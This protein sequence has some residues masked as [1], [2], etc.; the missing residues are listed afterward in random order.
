MFSDSD[1][2]RQTVR[3]LARASEQG[4]V[5]P[6]FDQGQWEMLGEIG[7]LGLGTDS[8][9]GGA[10]EIVCAMEELGAAGFVGPLVE[11]FI[12]T[13]TVTGTL[14]EKLVA[15]G[16]A[17]VTWNA[18]II[19]WAN[20]A[21]VTVL[22]G[23]RDE[24][25]VCTTSALEPFNTLGRD[26]SS[27]GVCEPVTSL[28]ENSRAVAIGE[29]AISGYII[30]ASQRLVQLS[31]E[32][33][34][35]RRQFGKSIGEFQAVSHPLAQCQA[36]LNSARD[37]LWLAARLN[38]E[39]NP[40]AVSAAAR[41]RLLAVESAEKVVSVAI[42]SHGGM[43]FVEGT[44]VTHL[45]RRIRHVS[46]LGSPMSRTREVAWSPLADRWEHNGTA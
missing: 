6:R 40:G 39:N 8:G 37:L 23:E 5:T 24:A 38:V 12:A 21:D 17:S 36:E 13:H 19:P 26:E 30:G 2:F 32:Y 22:F 4:E 18:S 1:S 10:E 34:R 33:A 14:L 15:G 29:L 28:G 44:I 46:L 35:D 27:Y 7:V 9:G 41:A 45:A 31:A 25:W 42:Q 20:S 43:G 16:I 11:G 3:R